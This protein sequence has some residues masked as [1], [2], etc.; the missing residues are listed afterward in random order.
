MGNDTA[1]FNA[2]VETVMTRPVVQMLEDIPLSV[3][4]VTPR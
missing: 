1:R 4:V 2:P 3:F